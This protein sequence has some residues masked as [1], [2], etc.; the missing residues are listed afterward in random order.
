MSNHTET[1]KPAER[2][3]RSVL[4]M[5]GHKERVLA[6]VDQT[7]CDAVILDLEDSVGPADKELAR[8][9]VCQ[10]AQRVR[11]MPG[12]PL[13]TIRVNAQGTPWHADDVVAALAAPIDAVVVPK[14]DTADQGH[15]LADMLAGL[16]GVELWPMIE[17]PQ[18]VVEATQIAACHPRVGALIAGTNDLVKELRAQ[19]T[20]DRSGVVWCL[21]QM[22]VAARAAG[23][24]VVDGVFN[25]FRNT[26][27]FV[28]EAQQGKTLGFDGK[29]LIHPGQVE[30]CHEVFN[31]SPEDIDHALAVIEA[32]AAAGDGGVATVG[33]VMIEALHVDMARR[34]LAL[35]DAME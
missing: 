9:Q 35:A 31:P 2:V 17:T 12:R 4:Y 34:V 30:P 11:D 29:T 25:D 22:V 3:L 1:M 13:V 16:D 33:G 32:F 24:A 28:A 23:I 14:V 26:E 8:R 15:R 7:A 18:A 21:S 5:P 27:A 6:K 19:A 10:A 20:P